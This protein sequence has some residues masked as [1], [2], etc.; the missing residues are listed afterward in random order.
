[1]VLD[2]RSNLPTKGSEMES[3]NLFQKRE[4][5]EQKKGV[6]NTLAQTGYWPWQS[7]KDQGELE[8]K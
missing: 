6:D 5:D 7:Y 8:W 4:T 3:G 1:M 2:S